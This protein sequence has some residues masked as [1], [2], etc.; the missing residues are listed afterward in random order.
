M[1]IQEAA[2][3]L[4][5]ELVALNTVNPTLVPGAPGERPAVE[6]L[7]ARLGP[8]GFEIEVV[9]PAERPSLIA[10]HRGRG[11]RSIALNGHLDTVGVEG[12]EDP[13]GARIEGERMYGRGT[14]DMKAGVA[15]MVVA[16]EHAAS[17]GHDGDVMLA[18][19]ADEE[20]GSL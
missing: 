3:E 17:A 1:E 15:A 19:V 7:A 8:Q 11:G 12:M 4:T 16:A 5:R 20:H 18:L 10:T 9:G 6:L 14:C 2:V 13:F